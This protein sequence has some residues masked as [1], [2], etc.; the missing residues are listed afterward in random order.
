M[1]TSIPVGSI[2]L[3]VQPVK[4]DFTYLP[5]CGRQNILYPLC[6]TGSETLYIQP[7]MTKGSNTLPLHPVTCGQYDV[8]MRH[9]DILT[10]R[11]YEPTL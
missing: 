2:M 5:S 1:I 9:R 4:Q 3:R 7:V 11:S 8:T 10:V 6:E